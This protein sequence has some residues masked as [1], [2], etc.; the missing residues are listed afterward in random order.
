MFLN[1]PHFNFD[2][3]TFRRGRNDFTALG[4]RSARRLRGAA[5]VIL[6]GILGTSPASGAAAPP[7]AV[8]TEAQVG[9]R[10]GLTVSVKVQGPS[11]QQTPLQVACVFEYVEGDIFTSPPALPAAANGMV[12]LDQALRGLVTD[13]R[14]SGKFAGHALETVLITPPKGAIAAKRLLLIGLGDRKTFTP[15]FMQQVGAVGM[16]EALRLGVTSYSHAS[17][18]KDGG[19]ASPTS[20]VADAVLTGAFDALRA[21]STSR[22]RARARGPPYAL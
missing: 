20:N 17:D 21:S 5:L 19:V 14:K 16:R 13:L 4:R 10:D 9:Q 18:L 11:M 1:T 22:T 2:P 7:A 3:E 12:H 6:L 8:G 15:A